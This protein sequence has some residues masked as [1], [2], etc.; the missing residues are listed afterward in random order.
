[1]GEV[2]FDPAPGWVGVVSWLT[3]EVYF[4][5]LPAEVE[6]AAHLD[7]SPF[8][9][10]AGRLLDDLES[11][12]V[13][14]ADHSRAT[15]FLATLGR[16]QE[17]SRLRGEIK[18]HVRKGGWSQ[19]RYERRR[20][21]EIHHYC[22]AILAR[23]EALMDEEG[24]RRI[25]LAGDKILMNELEKKMQPRT[26]QRVVCR[27]VADKR[28]PPREFFAETLGAAEAEERAEEGR[29][30]ESILNEQAAGGAA[31]TGTAATFAALKE[32]RVR[33][34]LIGPMTGVGFYRCGECGEFGPGAAGPCPACGGET[35]VQDA[36]NEFMDLAF[37]AGS[38]VEFTSD[39]LP[40][41]G[42]VGALLRW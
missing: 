33:W 38:Q 39:P 30:R 29:L 42:G 22:Q 32:K 17:E 36:A 15:I 6:P 13:V 4:V 23:L 3:E 5:P 2:D 8:L 28:T 41:L 19:Q 40:D 11:Y 20:D 1:V 31:V 7:N 27:L 10:P 34:L 35:Y 12:A 25:V 26:R 24:L 21:K 16:W 37:G 9:Y 18:N 14:Y